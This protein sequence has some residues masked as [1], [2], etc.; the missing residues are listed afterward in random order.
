MT[1][2]YFAGKHRGVIG[3]KPETPLYDIRRLVGLERFLRPPDEPLRLCS[4]VDLL[5]IFLHSIASRMYPHHVEWGLLLMAVLVQ[6]PNG[7]PNW[8]SKPN[9][10]SEASLVV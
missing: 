8:I 6:E 1:G 7:N 3:E 10:P 2:W 5:P 4:S 9:S